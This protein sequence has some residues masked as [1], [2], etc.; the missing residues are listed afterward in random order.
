[1]AAGDVCD[2][3]DVLMDRSGVNAVRAGKI[4]ASNILATLTNGS[5]KAFVP[6]R[7]VLY[8]ISTGNG[9]AIAVWG[10]F[11]IKGNFVWYLKDR[12]DRRFLRQFDKEVAG[13]C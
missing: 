11:T 4:V 7:W 5:L 1:M 3:V 12:I 10:R 2:R 9:S 8:L 6:R 13:G